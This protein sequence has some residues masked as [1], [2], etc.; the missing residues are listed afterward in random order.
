MI[1]E[2]RENLIYRARR[3]D[4][5]PEAVGEVSFNK[6]TSDKAIMSEQFKL[7]GPIIFLLGAEW[8]KMSLTKSSFVHQRGNAFYTEKYL[9]VPP[10]PKPIHHSYNFTNCLL[11]SSNLFS[12]HTHLT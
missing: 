8:K 4:S 6:T 1:P 12:S 2:Y 7:S 9:P 11:L 10:L 5:D 3:E